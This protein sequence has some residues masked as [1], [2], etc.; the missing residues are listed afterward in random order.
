MSVDEDVILTILDEELIFFTD[1]DNETQVY[2]EYPLPSG[3]TCFSPVKDG[4]FEAFLS[5]RYCELAE[6]RLCPS[7]VFHYLETKKD[8]VVYKQTNAVAIHRRVAGTLSNKI[9][10]FLAD[11]M[12]R[13]VRVAP[14]GWKIIHSK[15]VKFL[16]YPAD[17][18][19]VMPI[20]GGNLLSL[21]RPFVN[22]DEDDFILFVAFLV[23]SFSRSS[24]HY[25]AVVSSSKGTGKST[26]TKM[27]RSI[28]DPSTSDVPLT[29]SSEGDLKNLL[30]N[31]YMA[32]FDNT[33]A[34]SAKFSDILCAA[35][36]GSKE[37]KRKLYS[38]CD[39]V[40]LNLHNLVV[41]NGIDIVPHRSDLLDR[42]LLFELRPI[43]KSARRTDSEFWGA[44]NAE[45]P[46][47]LGAIF[48][49]LSKAMGILPTLTFTS[50]E[51]MA[52]A[53]KEMTAIA[54]ALGVEQK[55][56]ERI[57]KKS[58]DNLQDAYN[59]NSDFLEVI[60][61]YIR[62]KG[63]IDKPVSALYKELL[64]RTRT[65]SVALPES[66]SALSRRLNMEK[67]ALEAAGYQFSRKRV[68]DLNHVVITR[69]PKNQQTKA[70]RDHQ[71]RMNEYRKNLLAEDDASVED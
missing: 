54:V 32:A 29:P 71:E 61:E 58:R 34:L 24:S 69:I 70:Q 33:A 17:K 15:N 45:K 18:A 22:L 63:N 51:R 55:E 41:I 7:D 13:S 30:A 38:D 62:T 44:F 28:I 26:L 12:R 31:T 16:K 47:I 4:R 57:F 6:V 9:L 5:H 50:L 59:Q 64:S 1:R 8:D 53:H 65:T 23:Q 25:A 49:T 2:V 36:T 68:G 67:D 27:L 48:D 21:L 37:V 43:P 35:I 60:I 42:S 20:G 3:A 56:F 11:E 46:R 14:G 52:D 19:Q 39:Q 40:I 66:P 10:Y